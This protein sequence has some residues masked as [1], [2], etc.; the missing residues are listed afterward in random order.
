MYY[1]EDS[2]RNKHLTF[3]DRVLISDFLTE[4]LS[5]KEIARRLGKDP[6]TI[7]KEVKKNSILFQTGSSGKKF[8]NCAYRNTCTKSSVCPDCNQKRMPKYCRFCPECIHFCD[9]Y[10]PVSCPKLSKPPYV[11]N[12]C[13]E[14]TRCTLEKNI[15]NGPKAQVKYKQLLSESRSGI[16]FSEQEV[17]ELDALFSPLIKQGQ[18]IHHIYINHKDEVMVSESTIY[19][20][21]DYSLF[22]ARNIDMPRKVRFAPKKKKKIFK[23]DKRCRIN[24]SYVDFRMFCNN[25]PN[26]PVTQIDSVEGVKGGKVLLTIHFVKAECMIA[27]IRDK[28]D[29]AS[30]TA[31]FNHLYESLTPE[32][33][34]TLMPLILGDNGSEFSDPR[35]I[36]LDSEGNQRTRV[37]YC[38]PSS[39]GQKGSA[40]R[41]HE[42]IRLFVPK[43]KS[44]DDLEQEDIDLM[45]S[46]IASYSRPSL[47]DKTPYEMM[48]FYYGRSV[49]DAL[50]LT[51]IEPDKVTLNS[52]IWSGKEAEN[53]EK[54]I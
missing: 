25:N 50:K 36:E 43:G 47:M 37:F 24:R 26:L 35:A 39:P 51:Y 14:R 3:E 22:E 54:E 16:S 1:K 33:F 27:F 6:T 11:C 7:A 53:E 18:S 38:D 41:N 5:F 49:C 32:V 9:V 2:K 12:G 34:K 20:L 13:T 15:Y 21:V 17:K 23:V 10:K 31:A 52:S 46:H 30:V 28:N 4:H 29:A 48:E 45:M 42:F 19:N 44:F 8:N 40:E